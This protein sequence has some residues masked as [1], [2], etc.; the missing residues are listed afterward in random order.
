MTEPSTVRRF[1][2]WPEEQGPPEGWPTV[3]VDAEDWDR[4]EAAAHEVLAR[5]KTGEVGGLTLPG[6][7]ALERLA[8]ALRHAA[9][10]FEGPPR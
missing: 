6:T 7:E 8:A 9:G 10:R 1:V 4:L 3:Y 5:R 2:C